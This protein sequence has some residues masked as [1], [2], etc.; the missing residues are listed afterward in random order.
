MSIS[1]WFMDGGIFMYYI[2]VADLFAVV[3]IIILASLKNKYPISPLRLMMI[4]A[5]LLPLLVG[6]FGY[7]VGY[8]QL[9]SALPSADPA[10]KEDLY[11]AAMSVVAIPGIFGGVSA[12]VL[13]VIGYLGLKKY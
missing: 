2:I 7:W 5:A 4:G 13:F 3:A 6:A 8:E 11:N 10:E 12:A 9:M 1:N